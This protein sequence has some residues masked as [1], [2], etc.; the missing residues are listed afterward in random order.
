[1]PRLAYLP[2]TLVFA[3]ASIAAIFACNVCFEEDRR[4]PTLA[5]CQR[6]TIR[7]SYMQFCAS[8]NLGRR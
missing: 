3:R 5:V 8:R 6:L 2:T 1:M 7:A 4:S